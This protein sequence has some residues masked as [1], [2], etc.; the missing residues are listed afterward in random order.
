MQPPASSDPIFTSTAQQLAHGR[1]FES[2]PHSAIG[3]SS[4]QKAMVIKLP[5]DMAAGV[6][7]GRTVAVIV[8]FSVGESCFTIM[9]TLW[10]E[11]DLAPKL[12]K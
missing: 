10:V 9:T 11:H 7:R 12:M 3:F 2:E 6:G 1:C 4:E 8:G 5:K